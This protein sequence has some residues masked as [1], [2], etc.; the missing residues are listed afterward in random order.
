MC[1]PAVPGLDVVW[2]ALLA[3]FIL[4]EKLTRP[5]PREARGLGNMGNP[6]PENLSHTHAVCFFFNSGGTG[7]RKTCLSP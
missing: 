3:P 5:G 7:E 4:E 1:F 6:S 2:N